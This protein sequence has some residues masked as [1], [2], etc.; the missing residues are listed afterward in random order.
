MKIG[1]ENS[2]HLYRIRETREGINCHQQDNSTDQVRRFDEVLLDA[3]SRDIEEK[4][5]SEEITDRLRTEIRS[6]GTEE[7]INELKQA[8]KEGTYV[9]DTRKIAVCML[10]TEG[11]K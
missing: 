1:T 3:S 7:R 8:V 10:I 5:L 2:P 11:E 9:L 6:T 4:L